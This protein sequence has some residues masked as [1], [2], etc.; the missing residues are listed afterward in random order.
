[1]AARKKRAAKKKERELAAQSSVQPPGR[2]TVYTVAVADE[3]VRR[4]SLGELL[5]KICEEPEMPCRTT[6]WNW[7]Q[8]SPD[9]NERLRGA[10]LKQADSLFEEVQAIADDTPARREDIDKAKLRIDTRKFRVARLNRA[11]YGDRQ[12]LNIAGQVGAPPVQTASVR[13]DL[14][15]LSSVDQ[16]KLRELARKVITGGGGEPVAALPATSREAAGP[17]LAEP[18]ENESPAT[19]SSS[20]NSHASA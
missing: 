16:D 5:I 14:S 11:L 12:D 17:H 6:V 1:M 7:E 4:L 8:L 20:Q 15:H 9:F 13:V 2:P 3:I 19:A 18:L 10:R